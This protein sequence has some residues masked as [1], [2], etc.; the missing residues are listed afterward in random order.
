M[1]GVVAVTL[2]VAGGGAYWY[3]SEMA[4]D[5]GVTTPIGAR[6]SGASSGAAGD[7]SAVAVEAVKV[8]I[9]AI[10][11]RI[12]ALG[13]TMSDESVIIRPEVSGRIAQ[14]HFREGERVAGDALLVSLDD[15][16]QAA[17][18]D[19]ARAALALSLTTYERAVELFNRKAGTQRAVDEALGALRQ[20]QARV[21]LQ[22]ATLAKNQIRAPFPGM[23]GLRSASIGDYVTP[24]QPIVNLESI[25]MIKIDFRVPEVNLGNVAV[26]QKIEVRI[27]AFPDRTFA[28][29][30]FAID[31]LVDRS[32]H[33]IVLRARISNEAGP[34]RPGMFARVTLLADS[35]E[36]VVL[37]PEQSIV[38]RGD[39]QF[40]YRI[41][42]GHARLTRVELGQRRDA[43]V[44]IRGGLA[45]D[46]MVVTAGQM[47]LSDGAAVRPVP[48]SS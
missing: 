40:V 18:L 5:T 23:I 35:R 21:R 24:G 12:E 30:V 14:I 28:G 44:E 9:G 8:T 29:E 32:G 36:G 34:V 17:Q 48:P 22:E 45:R 38:P 33:A 15:S 11:R 37:V 7:A 47:K 39:S 13:T 25:D 19:Q 4:A 46:D 10:A 27:D 41:V 31:P 42:D 2:L 43:M 26:G 6:G 1:Q 20:D 16:I 3:W